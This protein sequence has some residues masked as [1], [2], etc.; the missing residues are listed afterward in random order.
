M[1][2]LPVGCYRARAPPARSVVTVGVIDQRGA[3]DRVVSRGAYGERPTTARRVI[4]RCVLL[5]SASKPFAVLLL[6]V[7]FVPSALKP[8]AVFESPV[9][10]DSKR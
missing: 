10:L 2:L 5:K 1:L 6:P 9:V 7:L 4:G 8:V 3:T